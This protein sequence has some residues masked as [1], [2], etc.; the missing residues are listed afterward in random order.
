MRGMSNALLALLLASALV[1]VDA[2]SVLGP[3]PLTSPFV[4]KSGRFTSSPSGDHIS[5]DWPLFSISTTFTN[6]TAIALAGDWI[7]NRWEVR[8]AAVDGDVLY[9]QVV[10]PSTGGL[11][12]F[13][14]T[15]LDPAAHYALSVR[16]LTEGGYQYSA[17]C[18]V[19]SLRELY[20][21]AGAIF[22]SPPPPARRLLFFGD[23]VTCG[24]GVDGQYPCGFSVST[25]SAAHSYAGRVADFL[26]ADATMVAWSG[27]GLLRNY[28]SPGTRDSGTLPDFAWQ[29][30]ANDADLAWDTSQDQYDAVIIT[31]GG[32]DFSTQPTPSSSDWVDALVAFCADVR[33]HYPDVPIVLG[34]GP[35][36]HDPA[37]LVAAAFPQVAATGPTALA[38]AQG[39][40]SSR[41]HPEE[42]G[43]DTH[44]GDVVATRMSAVFIL[45]LQE[46]L[47]WN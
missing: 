44:P 10:T 35:M 13:Y 3:F 9:D 33:A 28:G 24:Y 7:G 1:L 43:C 45:A 37:D 19:V 27:R 30:L 39:L 18:G 17:A 36:S 5:V 40:M 42:V 41:R 8:L 38:S 16:K 11:D 6:S 47:E 4:R 32:N 25:E 15:D 29:T 26:G 20:A 31:I 22:A 12:L 14:L 34:T 2:S 21:D 46:L 23:S